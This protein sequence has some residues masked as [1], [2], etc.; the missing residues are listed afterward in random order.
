[1]PAT[2]KTRKPVDKLLQSDMQAFPIWE[3]A[4]DEESI[5]GRDETWVRPV[6]NKHVPRDYGPYGVSAVVTIA[7]SSQFRAVA[8]VDGRSESSIQGAAILHNRRYLYIPEQMDT[9]FNTF[10]ML[11]KNLTG[12]LNLRARDVFP[13]TV[14]LTVKVRGESDVRRCILSS[15]K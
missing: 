13:I 4:I 11:L 8:W 15:P 5:P 6:K 12:N 14:E 10:D 7:N 2:L 3:F 1:M 9:R